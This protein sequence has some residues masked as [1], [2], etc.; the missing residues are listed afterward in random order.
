MNS[1]YDDGAYCPVCKHPMTYTARH[2]NHIGHYACASCGYHRHDPAYT[3]TGVDMEK[4]EMVILTG[5]MN[6]AP[7]SDAYKALTSYWK[8]GN[9]AATWGTLS[10]SSTSYYY[11]VD[12]F[13]SDRT[14][15][16]IDH[17]MTRGFTAT[18]YSRVIVT[19]TLDGT[20]WC[21]S[22]HLPV[23]ATVTTK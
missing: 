5:D 15:R 10:G 21:P 3:V 20:V 14:D 2:Y 19:Y 7:G 23:K 8:D 22:D 6:S 9:S 18:D 4:G 16:R 12:V 1:V 11:P 13:T 17:I